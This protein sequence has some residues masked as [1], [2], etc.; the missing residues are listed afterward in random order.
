MLKV[1]MLH[2]LLDYYRHFIPTN[3]QQEK[4]NFF[5]LLKV[6]RN[7][8]PQFKYR[9]IYPQQRV[10]SIIK[11][12]ERRDPVSDGFIH[13][14]LLVSELFNAWT[15]QDYKK[16]TRLSGNI[17]GSSAKISLKKMVNLYTSIHNEPTQSISYSAHDVK[18]LIRQ[19]LRRLR[20][21]GWKIIFS[22]AEGTEAA[23]YAHK[24]LII[25]KPNLRLSQQEV[26]R[27]VVHEIQGHAFQ[28]FNTLYLSKGLTWLQGYIGTEQQYEGLALFTEIN[29]LD[30]Q[31]ITQVIKRYIL[32]MIA[33]RVAL[34]HPFHGVYRTIY[35]LTSDSE[36]SFM[37]AYR[38]K[39]GFQ[40]TSR[41][42]SMQLDNAYLL[43]T[44]GLIRCLGENKQNYQKV[45]S[46]SFPLSI[47]NWIPTTKNRWVAVK[48]FNK[49][50]IQFFC[51]L[52]Q[53]LDILQLS[54]I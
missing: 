21:I 12:I 49:K 45:I 14:Y 8:D 13:L 51:S 7:Y 28:A 26:D 41:S 16:L 5:S 42:G 30:K 27:L 33:I 2:K 29:L 32:F 48:R 47:I 44:L 23:L 38:S 46:G 17:F 36:L 15:K 54:T 53:S 20:L 6:G 35:K 3:Y 1:K 24:K 31:S 4:T 34:K 9:Y 18:R 22:D 39:Y 52:L 43:G 25:L 37:A 50:N 10:E 40:N 19:R 11:S